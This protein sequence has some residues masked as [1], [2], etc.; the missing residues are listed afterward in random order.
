MNGLITPFTLSVAAQTNMGAQVKLQRNVQ[1]VAIPVFQ[2]GIFSNTDLAFFNGPPFDFGGRIH[3]NGNLWLA[4]NAGPLYIRDNVTVVGQVI[5][6]NLE[7][8][9][10]IDRRSLRR[11]GYHRSGSDSSPGR[12]TPGALHECAMARAAGG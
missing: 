12:P 10:P 9:F 8:G 4:A 5:R 3:T 2:F 11:P 6:T 7:N 1:L